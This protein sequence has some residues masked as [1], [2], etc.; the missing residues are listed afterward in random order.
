MGRSMMAVAA[1]AALTA[2]GSATGPRGGALCRVAE[3]STVAALG[4]EP[5]AILTTSTTST[6]YRWDGTFGS[7]E[8]IFDW[9][10]GACVVTSEGSP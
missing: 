7:Y 9:S 3:D 5:T 1:I 4:A 8:V 10:S 6:A 2:C